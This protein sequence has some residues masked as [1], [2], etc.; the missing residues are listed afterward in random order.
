MRDS[1]PVDLLK[2]ND[3]KLTLIIVSIALS[4]PLIGQQKLSEQDYSLYI[5]SLIG[6]QREYSVP[7]G[8]VD[9]VTDEYAIEIEKA[10]NWKES[11]GQCLWYA[12]NTNKQ[13]AI[14]L[15]VESTEQ[16]KHVVQL[17]TTLHY[18]HL[19][20]TIKLLVFPNDFEDL[21]NGK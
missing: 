8:R 7:N 4:L 2:P 16:Y 15:I 11:I 3:M 5:Q 20:E 1:S 10:T 13:P 12:L 21:M 18:S 19:S 9:L 6:G 14:I 17:Q